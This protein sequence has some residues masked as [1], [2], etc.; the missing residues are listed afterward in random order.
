MTKKFTKGYSYIRTPLRGNIV[1]SQR[2]YS[3]IEILLYLALLS[4]FIVSLSNLFVSSIDLKLESEATSAVEIDSRYLMSRFRYDITQA[5]SIS[6]PVALGES[7]GTLQ[8]TK[9]GTNY[10]YS[11]DG[12]GDLVI[13]DPVNLDQLNSSRTKVS[14]INFT[15]L[16]NAGGKNTVTVE[17]TLESRIFRAGEPEVRSFTITYATR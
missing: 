8:I 15:K 5:S 3:F 17:F 4:I 2:G 14:S 7:G 1:N 6:V 16:G 11:V 9:G 12:N 10:T 13:S